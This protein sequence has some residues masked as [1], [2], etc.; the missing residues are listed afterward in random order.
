MN[1]CCICVKRINWGIG[2]HQLTLH[3]SHHWWTRPCL[4]YVC[5]QLPY[6]AWIS[7][8]C[9]AAPRPPVFAIYACGHVLKGLRRQNDLILAF[10]R[11][12]FAHILGIPRASM[13]KIKSKLKNIQRLQ[14]TVR[15][16]WL[17]RQRKHDK[18]TP[19]LI[20]GQ[21]STH[22]RWPHLLQDTIRMFLDQCGNQPQP[23]RDALAH[24]PRIDWNGGTRQF[25][26]MLGPES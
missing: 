23:L 26:E 15:F 6:A 7:L 19:S 4:K 16:A 18:A 24:F 9:G 8:V 14:S 12:T 1:C 10:R 13:L 21:L 17:A 22:S 2:K 20:T 5:K 3:P 25:A 11:I